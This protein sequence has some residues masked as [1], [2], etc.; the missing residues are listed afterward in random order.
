[1]P[2]CFLDIPSLKD[3]N[4][5]QKRKALLT[6]MGKQHDARKSAVADMK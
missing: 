1:M 3:Y 5:G 6:R 4:N 2:A